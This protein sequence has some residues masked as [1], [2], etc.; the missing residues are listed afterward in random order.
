[1][2]SAE[3]L[4]MPPQLLAGG[5]YTA[6]QRAASN[7]TRGTVRL[8]IGLEDREDL[9]QDLRQAFDKAFA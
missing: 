4:V 5:E 2:G 6:E 7:I 3:S 9:V 8:S 1:V